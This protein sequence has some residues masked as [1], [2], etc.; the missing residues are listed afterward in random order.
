MPLEAQNS[1][2]QCA[3]SVC[4]IC[5]VDRLSLSQF[6]DED[7]RHKEPLHVHLLPSS[8]LLRRN[9][10]V[11]WI[12]NILLPFSIVFTSYYMLLMSLYLD[13]ISFGPF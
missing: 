2:L 9:P 6:S 13:F 3:A 4:A 8:C 10:L 5:F 1:K 11:K 12:I 7:N